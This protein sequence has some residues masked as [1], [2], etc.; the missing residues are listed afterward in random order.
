[1]SENTPLLRDHDGD[2]VEETAP[3]PAAQGDNV[4]PN[5]AIKF[6][7]G[8]LGAIIGLCGLSVLFLLIGIANCTYGRGQFG[9]YDW[10]MQDDFPIPITISVRNPLC[11]CHMTKIN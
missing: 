8:H 10:T 1:M 2:N 7:H 4:L 9:F 6:L 11:Y 5:K 3:A